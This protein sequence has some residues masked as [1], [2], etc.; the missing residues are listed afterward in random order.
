MPAKNINV[1]VEMTICY[2]LIL[3]EVTGREINFETSKL[4]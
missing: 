2:R 4:N 3:G 1:T